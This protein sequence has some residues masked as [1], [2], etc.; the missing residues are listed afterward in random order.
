MLHRISEAEGRDAVE[1]HFLRI[2]TLKEA[3]VKAT[4][5]GISAPPGLKGFR[6]DVCGALPGSE[7]AVVPAE[8]VISGGNAG[9]VVFGSELPGED[10]GWRFLAVEP[11]TTHM[12]ALCIESGALE[13]PLT[14]RNFLYAPWTEQHGLPLPTRAVACS[15]KRRD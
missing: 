8:P 4:G 1:E 7:P 6:V 12:A 10:T 2:W 14:V 11:S 13:E 3:F 9:E 15:M 5:R